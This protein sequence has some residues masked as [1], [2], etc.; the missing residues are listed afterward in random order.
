MAQPKTVSVLGAKQT[1]AALKQFEPDFAKELERELREVGN[2]VAGRARA[3]AP[4]NYPISGWSP[5]GRTGW[6]Q[7][8][9]RAG[10]GVRTFPR[11]KY[12]TTE[13]ALVGITSGNAAAMIFERAGIRNRRLTPQGRAFIAKLNDEYGTGLRLVGRVANASIGQ[14]RRKIDDIVRRATGD[15]QD[16]LDRAG[17]RNV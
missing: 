8:D 11:R 13:Q 7:G 15:L 16:S 2:E 4:A 10:I 6:R 12:G 1:I 9:V 3:Y 14:T 17:V 5:G